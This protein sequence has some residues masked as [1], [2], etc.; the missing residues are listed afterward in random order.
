VIIV[1]DAPTLDA[2]DHHVVVGAGCVAARSACDGGGL[3]EPL[4]REV[5][6]SRRSQPL[7]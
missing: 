5:K 1:K 4:G 3:A 2:T 7:L 6:S